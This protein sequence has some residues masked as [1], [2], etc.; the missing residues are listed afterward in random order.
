MKKLIT[1]L[2]A[3]AVS[4]SVHAKEIAGV[5]VPETL[6]L[7][8]QTLT[9]NGAG[10]RSKFFMDM[11]V[12]ALYTSTK[13]NNP[14][15][16]LNSKKPVA[17]KLDITSKL[18][19]SDVMADAVTQGFKDATN[20]NMAP[21]EERLKSFIGVFSEEIVKGDQFVMMAIPGKGLD[22]YKNGK[23]LTTIKGEDFSKTLL[24]VWLGSKPADEK[25]KAK[26][27]GN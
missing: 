21:L 1:L 24:S 16:I 14:E 19:S 22:V 17:I 4:L 5:N 7:E 10:I 9:L 13:S 12:G 3:F 18:I 25:L 23:L 8:K 27:L 11:Y 20:N 2:M 6:T 26:M 15:A